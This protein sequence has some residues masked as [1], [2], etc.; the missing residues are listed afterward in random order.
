MA[1]KKEL[2]KHTKEELK[3]LQARDLD[4]KIHHAEA[5]ILEFYHKKNGMVYVSFSG[6]KDSTVLLHLIRNILPNVPAVFFDTGL[7]FPEIK[8]FVKSFDNTEVV[9]PSIS[10]RDVIEKHG[11]PLISKKV[12]DSVNGAIRNPN[13]LRARFFTDEFD[14]SLYSMKRFEYLKQAPFKLNDKCCRLMKKMP[15]HEYN[16]KSGRYPYTGQMASES[17]NRLDVWLSNGCNSFTEGHIISNPLSIW[18]EDDIQEYIKRHSII[19]AKPYEMG[20]RRTGCV[21]CAFGV[22]FDG[23]PN[24]FQML[25]RTHPNLYE[26]MMKPKSE[27][28]LGF[29]EPLEF[30]GVPIRDDQ[31]NMFDYINDK[32]ELK[33]VK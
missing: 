30:I 25:Q 21:Y 3:Q 8:E 4:Y 5:K 1:L 20:Y 29:K 22:N 10:F 6:G 17:R 7:E 12:C 27:G 11:Y 9:K 26:Y 16:K 23:Y 15:A 28:G 31:M 13:S 24:R 18:T 32:G 14:G 19:L 2:Q 33:N